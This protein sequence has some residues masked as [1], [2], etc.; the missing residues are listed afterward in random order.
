MFSRFLGYNEIEVLEGLETL[1][2]LTD[3]HVENQKLPKKQA[4]IFCPASMDTIA[5][6]ETFFYKLIM[7]QA[8]VTRNVTHQF[9]F[10]LFIV[11]PSILERKWES[12]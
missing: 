8:C 2:H 11:L 7:T 6:I 5:V 3:L 1:K 9:I 12:T 10:C 4:L